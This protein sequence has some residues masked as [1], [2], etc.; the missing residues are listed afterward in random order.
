MQ[1]KIKLFV[2]YIRYYSLQIIWSLGAGSVLGS[3]YFSEVRH[4]TPCELCW[5][6]R[7]LMY[8]MAIITTYMLLFKKKIEWQGIILSF[9]VPALLL[10]VFQSLMQWGI[11]SEEIT[12]CSAKSTVSCGKP[13]ILWLGFITIPFLGFLTNL[14]IIIV[15]LISNKQSKLSKWLKK[16]LS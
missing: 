7:I 4:F 5:W 10:G 1:G 3:L 8:P 12:Q 15:T 2:E 6:T 11:I 13:E 16:I 9:A 14:A